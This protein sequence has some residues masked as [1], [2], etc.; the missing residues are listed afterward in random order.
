[1]I[2]I[3]EISEDWKDKLKIDYSDFNMP[4]P[5]EIPTK[6][7]GKEFY[8][9]KASKILKNINPVSRMGKIKTE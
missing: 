1:M 7:L 9:I 3:Y 5:R 8:P 2:I 4:H 6:R